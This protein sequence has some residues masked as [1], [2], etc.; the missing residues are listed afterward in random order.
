MN[1]FIKIPKTKC[2][3]SIAIRSDL[4]KGDKDN[5]L[6]ECSLCG[7]RFYISELDVVKVKEVEDE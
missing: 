2:C 6:F 4:W 7:D 1:N 3:N 5:G